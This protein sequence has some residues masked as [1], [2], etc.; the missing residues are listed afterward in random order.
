MHT[1]LT[2]VIDYRGHR[3]VGQSIIPGILT[4]EKVSQ[5]VYG[6]MDNGKTIARDD[7]FHQLVLKAGM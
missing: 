1:I 4:N 5:V 3:V 6:S 7:E 2:A